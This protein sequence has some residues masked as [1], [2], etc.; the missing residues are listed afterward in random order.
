M[1]TPPV[2]LERFEQ[3]ADG[4]EYGTVSLSLEIKMGRPRYVISREESYIPN[5]DW[6]PCYEFQAEKSGKPF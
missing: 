2:I 4:L 5:E 6:F 3:A 1:K